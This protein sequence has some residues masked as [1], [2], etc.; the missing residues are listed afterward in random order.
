MVEAI[1]FP[2]FGLCQ[3]TQEPSACILHPWTLKLPS[4]S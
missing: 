2:A 4:S 1:L 3:T